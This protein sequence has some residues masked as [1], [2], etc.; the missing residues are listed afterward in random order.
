[1]TRVGRGIRRAFGVPLSVLLLAPSVVIPVLDR[2]EL[3]HP[4]AV[5]QRGH[6]PSDCPAGHD[7]NL[8]MQ[9][10]ANHPVPMFG[11]QSP[12]PTE[13]VRFL[14]PQST[15]TASPHPTAVTHHPRAPPAA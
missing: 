14:E 15:T 1:M 3:E 5:E 6:D 12:H 10:R 9:V 8:C 7:H 2:A 11:T 13:V 4:L